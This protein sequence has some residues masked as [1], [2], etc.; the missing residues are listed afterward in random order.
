MAEKV[1]TTGYLT[2]IVTG[3]LW[4]QALHEWLAVI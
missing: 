4:T 1:D 3:S 2:M